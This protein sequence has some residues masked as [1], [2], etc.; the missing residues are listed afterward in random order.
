MAR[1]L[2]R[3]LRTGAQR[4]GAAHRKV[5]TMK[6]KI[7]QAATFAF[8]AVGALAIFVGAINYPAASAS[9][10]GLPV[11]GLVGAASTPAVGPMA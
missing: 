8:S 7:A 1:L 4:S 5:E 3:F 11:V 6:T 10:A 2:Q 9:A